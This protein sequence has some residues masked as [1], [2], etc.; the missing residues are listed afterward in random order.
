MQIALST[1]WNARRHTDGARLVEESRTAGFSLL[2]LGYD[3]RRDLVP[4]ILE[5][6]RSG[7]VRV[8]SVHNYC[9]VPMG[10][11][12]GH[13]ELWTFADPDPAVRRRAV[14][15]TAET[16]RFA[17]EAGATIVVV[18]AG[19]VRMKPLSR[20]LIRLAEKGRLDSWWGRRTSLALDR[21]RE[22]GVLR[23]LDW[24][25]KCLESLLPVLEDCK[26]N[27][28]LENLPS[29]EA[30]PAEREFPLLVKR[31]PGSRIRYWH[32]VGHGAIR[33]NLGWISH[34]RALEQLAPWLG[35]LH[36]HDILPPAQDHVVPG[37]GV[38]D[39][40]LFAPWARLSIPL[41]LEPDSRASAEQLRGA[42][43]HMEGAWAAR[44]AAKEPRPRGSLYDA[45]P[46]SRKDLS[47]S[48]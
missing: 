33:E 30:V 29:W 23:H 40:R 20:R 19:Y 18:H 32:D 21:R 48:P 22:R 37:E 36:L 43:A 26:V 12:T 35:G 17:A 44:V 11:P 7:G 6:V 28:G 39:F 13:P 4:G 16:V 34:L 42:V 45:M 47:D 8:V 5:Q 9:P 2:E 14:E 41:V 31:F 15:H 46:V 27:L 24:I 1:R 3:L 25:S 38:L 10:A